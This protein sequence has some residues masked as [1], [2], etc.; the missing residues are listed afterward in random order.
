LALNNLLGKVEASKQATTA[1]CSLDTQHKVQIERFIAD[2]SDSVRTTLKKM[3]ALSS[4]LLFDLSNVL[5]AAPTFPSFLQVRGKA[6][7][8]TKTHDSVSPILKDLETMSKQFPEDTATFKAAEKSLMSHRSPKADAQAAPAKKPADGVQGASSSIQ[9]IDA[10]LKSDDQVGS[11]TLPGEERM[12]LSNSG[13]LNKVTGIYST[14]LDHVHTKEKTVDDQLKWCGSIARDAKVDSDAVARSLKWTGAKLNLVRVAMSEYEGTMEF[15]RLQQS[16]MVAR[17]TQL[18]K[19]SDVEDSQLQQ[20]YTALKEYGQQLLSLASELGAKANTDERKGAEVVRGL[21]EKVEKHQGLL[22]QWRVQSKDRRQVVDTAFQA[23]Q[24]ALGDG[25][26]ASQRRLVRL[27]V[28]SQVLTSLAS[29]KEKDKQLSE[30]YVQ[31][32]QDLCSGSKAKQLQAKGAKLRQEA[33]AIQ[34]SLTALQQPMP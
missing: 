33:G 30:K 34:K 7:Q 18:Q 6:K 5:P 3:P 22:Q 14:L 4:E 10:F 31:L 17:S 25:V 23:V 13:D 15:N 32:S 20:S 26:K 2:E 9:N 16:A 8:H 1:M 28:E 21:L 29:S 19:L 24:Q 11:G 12:L 27:K